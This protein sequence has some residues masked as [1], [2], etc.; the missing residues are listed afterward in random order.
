MLLHAFCECYGVRKNLS[1]TLST[2]PFENVDD[3]VAI[4]IYWPLQE[5]KKPASQ[6]WTD[7]CGC[8]CVCSCVP[9]QSGNVHWNII[10]ISRQWLSVL[11]VLLLFITSSGCFAIST[12]FVWD[13][14]KF[15]REA[16]FWKIRITSDALR[17][18]REGNVLSEHC[19][20]ICWR[21]KL[22]KKKKK[23]CII[24]CWL[25]YYKSM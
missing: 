6:H 25:L 16:R 13:L 19:L 9:V 17:R 23:N 22:Q 11:Q 8:G 12:F 15:G 21:M 4:Y 1:N 7:S 5:E 14:R 2:G 20:I 18:P 24:K 10:A 3:I